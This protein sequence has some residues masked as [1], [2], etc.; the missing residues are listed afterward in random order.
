VSPRTLHYSGTL[1]VTSCWCGIPLAVPRELYDEARR[2]KGKHI[3]CPVGHQFVYSNTTQEQLA[4]A[5]RAL[6]RAK[7]RER[8]VRELLTHEEQ[9]H[10]ATKGHVT[11]KKKELA[12]VKNGVCPCCNRSFANLAR[13]MAGQHPDFTP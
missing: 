12:R 3:Y 8:A 9:S 4:E 10:R 5:E 13:H 7:Q 6:G 2:L 1:I 11:R